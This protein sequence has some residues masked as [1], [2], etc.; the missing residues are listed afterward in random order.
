MALPTP[1]CSS[2]GAP[3]VRRRT[4]LFLAPG[5]N[6]VAAAEIGEALINALRST[7]RRWERC[8]VLKQSTEA[9]CCPHV[10]DG[11][12]ASDEG[13]GEDCTMNWRGRGWFW[14]STAVKR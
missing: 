6:D 10:V 5:W 14:A 8:G 7:S 4:I 9:G 3:L 13:G 11:G 12:A 2:S 1:T